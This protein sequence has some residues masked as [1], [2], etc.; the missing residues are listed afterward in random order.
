[1]SHRLWAALALLGSLLC[2]SFACAQ[3]GPPFLTT[4]PGT[5]GNGNWEINVGAM[6][7]HQ[8]GATT[9]QLPQLDVNYGVGDRIQLTYT[10]AY[11]VQ[12]ASGAPSPSDYGNA[13]IGV[14]WRFFDQGEGGW[15]LS[16]FPQVE[17]AGSA[18]A[19]S[20]GLAGAGPRLLLPVE[21]QKRVGPLDVNL[22]VGYY[23]PRN[24]AD[25]RFLGLVVGRQVSERLELD[26]E[27]FADRASGAPPNDTT[28]DFGFRY[29][30]HPAF[31]LLCMA[32]RSVSSDPSNH[33]Q[34]M[35]Y[36]GLQILLSDYGRSLS[37]AP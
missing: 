32:G 26:A 27:V 11:V 8:G 5:P 29:K 14:K 3:G 19:Q 16:M 7:T 25:E 20:K 15:Q 22:E 33:T 36:L 1:M 18:L 35:G 28:L 37:S 23:W 24:G 17:T 6:A 21:V 10:G 13:F 34:F 9:W 4:D 12:T 31:I 30:L 2:A